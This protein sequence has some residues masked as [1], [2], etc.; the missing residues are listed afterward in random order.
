MQKFAL[1]LHQASL[2]RQLTYIIL[3]FRVCFRWSILSRQLAKLLLLWLDCLL[4][5]TAAKL[6]RLDCPIFSPPQS[7]HDSTVPYFYR[8]KVIKTRSSHIFTAAKLSSLECPIFSPP[9]S[10]HDSI[11]CPIF[12]PP[13]SYHDSIVPYFH[14]RKVIM[15]RMSNIFTAARLSRLDATPLQVLNEPF[16]HCVEH[17]RILVVKLLV[18]ITETRGEGGYNC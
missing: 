16:Q 9:Q 6:S 8:R 4:F 18:G 1:K 2:P 17:Y 3:I 13:K 10:Y 15:T 5:L 7:Y 11:D 14:R 12:S